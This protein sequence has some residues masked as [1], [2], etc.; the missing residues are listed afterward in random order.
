MFS[1][2]VNQIAKTLPVAAL[3]STKQSGQESE[4]VTRKTTKTSRQ[5][6]K[7]PMP[8]ISKSKVNKQS[9][10]EFQIIYVAGNS[11]NSIYLTSFKFL[12]KA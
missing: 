7:L 5:P 1:L 10:L 4:I 2:G 6:W 12:E 11:R 3:K 8:S 9:N